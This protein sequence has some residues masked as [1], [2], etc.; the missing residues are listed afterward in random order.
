MANTSTLTLRSI[1][2]KEN[3]L[4]GSN[5]LDWY[6]KLKI[7]LRHERKIYVLEDEP[8]KEPALDAS[9]EDQSYYSQYMEDALDVQ[10][11]MLSSMTPELQR[12][13]ENMSAKEIDQHL[14]E[15]FQESARVER[16]ETSRALFR[17]MLVE[18]NQVG[19][20]VLKMI[21]YIERLE[22]LGFKLDQDLAVDLVLSSLPPSFS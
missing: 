12:Q 4:L 20:H 5:Y 18:G 2:E 17:T 21:E 9:E 11:I 14:R 15:L 7:I 16:Y 3:I 10:C 22:S 8:L 19:S 13:H 1:L 6:R